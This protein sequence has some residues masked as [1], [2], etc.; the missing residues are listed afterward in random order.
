MHE[1]HLSR[2]AGDLGT[3]RACYARALAVTPIYS[4]IH[5]LLEY[6]RMETYHGGLREA[7]ELLELAVSRYPVDDKVWA[8]YEEYIVRVPTTST[9]RGGSSRNSVDGEQAFD[10]EKVTAKALEDLMKRKESLKNS[11]LVQPKALLVEQ[12]PY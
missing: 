2:Q 9:Y 8:A 6:V 11:V 1:G 10:S 7:K 4:G 3:A 12:R 5:V